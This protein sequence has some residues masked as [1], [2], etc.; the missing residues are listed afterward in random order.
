MFGPLSQLVI[1]Y[2]IIYTSFE[3]ACLL[4]LESCLD[5]VYCIVP[6]SLYFELYS[7]V[8]CVIVLLLRYGNVF[9]QPT[10]T[11]YVHSLCAL[12]LWV[13]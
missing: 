6:I 2:N 4:G 3:G 12:V 10:F 1:L 8:L 9:W 5:F 13:I 7:F 11:V